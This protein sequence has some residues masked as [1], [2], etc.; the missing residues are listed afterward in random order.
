[1]AEGGPRCGYKTV[2]NV[3]RGSSTPSQASGRDPVPFKA[4]HEWARAIQRAQ[5]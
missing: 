3:L 1:M 5:F 2:V 4:V